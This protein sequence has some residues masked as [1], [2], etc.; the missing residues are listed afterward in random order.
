VAG[1]LGT[2]DDLSAEV[3]QA[4]LDGTEE[5]VWRCVVGQGVGPLL[6]QGCGRGLQLPQE[7]LAAPVAAFAG[8]WGG[9]RG[10][11]RGS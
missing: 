9:R 11:S 10:R 5:F 6:Q 2:G 8:L 7:A 1:L 3:A 4:G